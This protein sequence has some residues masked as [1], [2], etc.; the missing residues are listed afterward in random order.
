VT[1]KGTVSQ[2]TVFQGVDPELDAEA[3]RVVNTLPAFTPGRQGGKPV[4]VWYT[5]P[6]TFVLK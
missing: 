6:I 1:S 3:V 4:P 2:V 5:V